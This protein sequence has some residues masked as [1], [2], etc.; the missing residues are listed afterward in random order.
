MARILETTPGEINQARLEIA[1]VLP[2]V[3]HDYN[4]KVP[5]PSWRWEDD[6]YQ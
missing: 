3:G 1:H 5:L 2:Q 4:M 6:L